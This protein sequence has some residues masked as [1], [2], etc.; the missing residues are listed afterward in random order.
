LT[1]NGAE[2]RRAQPIR[3]GAWGTFFQTCRF[4]KVCHASAGKLELQELI[5]AL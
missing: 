3:Q 4:K 1:D 5:T 2:P